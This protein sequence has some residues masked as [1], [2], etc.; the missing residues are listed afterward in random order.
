M[1]TRL[2][3]RLVRHHLP[4]FALS[5]A[6]CTILFFTRP[7]RDPISRAS[8]ATAYPALVLLAVTLALGPW[9]VLRGGR[10]PVSYDLRRDIGIWAGILSLLHTVIGQN[11][12]LRGRP[13]LYYVYPSSSHHSFPLRH[14]LFGVENMAGLL[15]AIAVLALLATSS[16][17]LL[18]RMGTVP[19]KRLQRWNYAAFALAGVH[20]VCYQWNEKTA[21]AF[22]VL[23]FACLT[24]AIVLQVAGL[25]ARRRGTTSARRIEG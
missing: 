20:T 2:Q 7:Y 19:W 8:F 10:V 24:A 15:S 23:G 18:R 12:H 5:S 21:H 13:W 11:V 16:D 4:L 9:R 1:H 3:R 6:V 25:I 17:L 14:D 22:H